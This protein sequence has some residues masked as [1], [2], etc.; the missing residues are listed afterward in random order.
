MDLDLVF[1]GTS[2]SVPTAR[3]GLTGTLIRRGG[4]RILVDCGEGT[5]R[6]LLRSTVGLAELPEV[7]VSHFHADHYLGL[8][9][10][11]K[12]F[13]LRGRELPLTVYGP[14]GLVDLFGA[15]RR[16]FGKLTY[17]LELVELRPG[18]S[19]DRGDYRMLVFKVAHGVTANGYALVETP[20]PGRFDVASA[21]A[22]GVE[23]GPD[24]GRLQRGETV[25][26]PGGAAVTPQQVLGPPRPGRKIV[27]AGDT[28]PARSVLD[29]AREAD[30]LV[31][32]ATFAAE[33][34][35][36]AAETA[37][38]TAVDAAELARA[39]G[40]RMLVLTHLS[41][42][43]FG[44][45]IAREAREVFPETVVPRD[46]DII[47]VRFP[48]RGGPRLFKAGGRATREEGEG[49][50]GH[51]AGGGSERPGGG[52][53]DPDDPALGGDPVGARARG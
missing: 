52:R 9:G 12:T 2:G 53:G 43:Y 22:L 28:A 3:R 48:E 30:V 46:F 33:E 18:E 44:P 27:L 34:R 38:S 49:H 20:R 16:I 50:G 19:L 24:F 31:H 23:E 40:V 39:A 41:N 35:D 32:E 6:Q 42:R 14:P 17:P 36:R 47:D 11:L 29:V 1:L 45:E 4:E 26:L 21:T 8:P 7:F 25:Q 5:Q 51:G 13:A 10:M 15:L 37:H